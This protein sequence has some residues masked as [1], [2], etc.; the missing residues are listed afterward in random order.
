MASANMPRFEAMTTGALLDRAF[1]LYANNFAL[2]LGIT[3]VAYVPLYIL[4]LLIQSSLA[5][6]IGAAASQLW[7][8]LSQLLFI[9]LWASIALPISVGAATYAISERYLGSEVTAA[10][11]L[12][13]AL[14][15]LWAMSVAQIMAGLRI[16]I[17]F[18]LLIVPGILWSLSYMLIVPA[19]MV[20]GLKAG[21]SLK[22]SWDLVRGHR[23]KVFMVIL[24]INLMVML[25]SYGVG[26][27][28]KVILNLDSSA[29]TILGKAI[30]N[31]VSVLLTPL[32]VITSILL[33]YDLRIRKEGFDLE[34]LSRSFDTAHNPSAPS[35]AQRP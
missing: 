7:V 24:V 1:R 35:M 12:I 2:L 20:E 11:S 29:G 26:S 33:Y 16:M 22:R 4:I 13:K 31:I 9:L 14:R 5:G 19:I 25:V 15:Q 21:P 28:A 27:L 8:I 10:Q 3:A 32:G 6:E 30:D 34:M 23:G 18:I 17:G